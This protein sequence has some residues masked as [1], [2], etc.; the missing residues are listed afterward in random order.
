MLE[1]QRR[2]PAL[3]ELGFTLCTPRSSEVLLLLLPT[4]LCSL[5]TLLARGRQFPPVPGKQEG[6]VDVPYCFQ[7]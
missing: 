2:N 4:L 6:N 1:V 3:C 7:P 5:S